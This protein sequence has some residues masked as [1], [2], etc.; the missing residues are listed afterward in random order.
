MNRY[1][2]FAA[3]FLAAVLF[4]A[5]GPSA[6][7]SQDL[8]A[9][10]GPKEPAPQAAPKDESSLTVERIQN[11]FVFGPDNRFTE[12]DGHYGNLLGGYA[13]Y[14]M[15]R[16][17]FVGVGGYWLTNGSQ[18]REMS[19]G[20]AVVE[21]LVH[22]N[23]RV[24]VSARALIGGG[25]ATLTSTLALPTPYPVPLPARGGPESSHRPGWE[26]WWPQGPGWPGWPGYGRFLEHD[27]YFVAEPQLNVNFKINGWIHISAG[28]GYRFVDGTRD[29]DHR[30]RGASGSLSVQL[31]GGS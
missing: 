24:G 17:L 11:G 23:R 19:Y 7:R 15:D 30:L 2:S 16:T 27:G 20:G 3:P 4:L 26:P 18:D 28:G 8:A 22:G 31:G 5:A 1:R 14:M 6:V 10:A 29:M 21:W 12:V 25:S 9:P 13:G